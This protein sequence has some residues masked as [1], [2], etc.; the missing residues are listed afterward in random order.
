MG[1]RY[2][3]ATPTSSDS[4]RAAQAHRG[5]G[6]ALPARAP[7]STK[8]KSCAGVGDRLV[9]V[10]VPRPQIAC[11]SLSDW[12]RFVLSPP[13]RT[14][15]PPL[16]SQSRPGKDRPIPRRA[17]PRWPYLPPS[18]PDNLEGRPE[19]YCIAKAPVDA[20]RCAELIPEAPVSRRGDNALPGT[21]LRRSSADPPD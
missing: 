15:P 17:W 6:P 3:D 12:R 20:I 10:P 13:A 16:C 4:H 8:V 1:A 21:P 14:A 19:K 18:R 5:S 7:S 11:N 2:S 9:S